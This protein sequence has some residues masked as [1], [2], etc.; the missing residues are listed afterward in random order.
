MSEIEP[1]DFGMVLAQVEILQKDSDRLTASNEARRRETIY[2][3]EKLSNMDAALRGQ[4]KAI[5][6]MSDEM[7]ATKS[8]TIKTRE[9]VAKLT[10]LIEGMNA[11]SFNWSKFMSGIVTPKGMIITIFAITALTAIILSITAPE[12]LPL[13]FDTV[14]AQ[15]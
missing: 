15:K 9:E 1:K 8:E 2:M 6:E 3:S 10:G 12:H 4:A 14:K 7:H 11:N 5:E 13:F